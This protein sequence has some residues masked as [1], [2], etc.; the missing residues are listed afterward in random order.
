MFIDAAP[1]GP[2]IPQA[3]SE[4]LIVLEKSISS[5]TANVPEERV[6]GLAERRT[7]PREDV[8]VP[9][10]ARA[11]HVHGTSLSSKRTLVPR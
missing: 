6:A 4:W 8:R 5:K 3:L 1:L 9:V 10:V 2:Q 7:L 11:S